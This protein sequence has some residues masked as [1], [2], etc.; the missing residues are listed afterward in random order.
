MNAHM[1]IK[2]V[3]RVLPRNEE[4]YYYE[5]PSIRNVLLESLLVHA[6]VLHKFLATKSSHHED[7]VDIN[8]E[9]KCRSSGVTFQSHA[10]RAFLSGCPSAP[11]LEVTA[12]SELSI[13]SMTRP[14][15]T[16]VKSSL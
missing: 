11:N 12:S 6:R 1:T 5:C 3:N 9:R 10:L 16:S 7:N 14:R 4:N 8:S 15:F 2:L 13:P